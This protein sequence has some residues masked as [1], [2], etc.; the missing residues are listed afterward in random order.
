MK[1]ECMRVWPR[2]E[3]FEMLFR[4]YMDAA[5][6]LLKSKPAAQAS[7]T[8][9]VSIRRNKSSSRKVYTTLHH[10]PCV[11]HTDQKGSLLMIC[12]HSFLRSTPHLA[13]R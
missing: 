9:Q 10:P 3:R 1:E 7:A 8:G 12:H 13:T 11:H 2:R 5:W 4:T 6:C